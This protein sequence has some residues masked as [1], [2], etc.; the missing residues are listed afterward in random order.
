[1]PV[2]EYKCTSCSAR[3]EHILLSF[4]DEQPTVCAACGGNL[5]KTFGG[6]VGVRLEGWGFSK[7]DALVSDDRPRRKFKELRERADR[8]VDE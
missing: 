3:E 5:K 4:S 6:R 8:I 1:M 7:N 2:Y